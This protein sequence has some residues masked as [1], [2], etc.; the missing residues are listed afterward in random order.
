MK[1]A[2]LLLG[3]LLI[4][5][6]MLLALEVDETRAY[7]DFVF[8]ITFSQYN[9]AY[10]SK[11]ENELGEWIDRD[12]SQNELDDMSQRGYYAALTETS[13]QH[14]KRR[15]YAKKNNGTTT[16]RSGR[17]FPQFANYHLQNFSKGFELLTLTTFTDQF[18]QQWY[19]ATWASHAHID[20]YL[21]DLN[22]YGISQAKIVIYE[23]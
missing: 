22:E 20:E 3:A 11:R 5:P 6:L 4:K 23:K 1:K 18:N 9:P 12:S 10:E 13:D 14:F 7:K 8:E 17:L 16:V 19:N 2:L 21:E 15:L